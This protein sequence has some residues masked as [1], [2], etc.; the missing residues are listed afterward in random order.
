[1]ENP[2]Q[3][4]TFT[5]QGRS[6][7][8]VHGESLLGAVRRAGFEVPSLCHHEA[9]SAYGACRL[10]LVEV[11]KGRKRKVTTSCNYPVQEGIT[12]LLDT[13]K[14]VRQR[15]VVFQLLLAMAPAAAPVRRLAAA[16]GVTDTP[17][18]P[19]PGNDCI[20]CGLCA[21]ACKEIVGL[22]AIAFAGRGTAKR[23][24][25][26]YDD[27]NAACIGCGACVVVCPTECLQMSQ[28]GLVRRLPRWQRD[29]ELQQCPS[30]GRPFA[31]AA[32]LAHFARE[33][34]ADA[35]RFERCLDCR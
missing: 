24:T 17:F 11:Q 3:K 23:M 10:C 6:V 32:Q 2:G 20:D 14:V 21:R 34:H 35:K 22:E 29:L 18:A 13:E 7:R 27:V 8:G 15:R 26:P 5:I 12:V 4:V 31:P 30:C 33:I 28:V 1:M 16:Y 9:V 25:T 19:D